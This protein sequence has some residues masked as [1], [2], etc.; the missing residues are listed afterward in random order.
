[1]GV[2]PKSGPFS[3]PPKECRSAGTIP[4]G[5]SPVV[6]FRQSSVRLPRGPFQVRTNLR[7]RRIGPILPD[8]HV[9]QSR[10]L[11]DPRLSAEARTPLKP[12]RFFTPDFIRASCSSAPSRVEDQALTG[13]LTPFGL[14]AGIEAAIP[15][16]SMPKGSNMTNARTRR[17]R[18]LNDAFRATLAGGKAFFSPGVSRRGEAFST[19]ALAAVRTFADFTAENDP[20]G[21][22]DFGVFRIGDEKMA[23]QIDY[24]DPSLDFGSQ[25]PADP[26]Q[27]TRV[28]TIM[29][30]E[31][32]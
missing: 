9:G 21:E 19:A 27:T 6:R 32:S 4:P 20:H 11:I 17:I 12:A 29:L 26:V 30:A 8:R 3:G 22:H 24:Y 13:A 25:D 31:E 7:A 10:P 23:W 2:S 18:E 1:M 15:A 5:F 14:S 28:L 16:G